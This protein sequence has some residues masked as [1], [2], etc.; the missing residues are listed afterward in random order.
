MSSCS[1]SPKVVVL[2]NQHVFFRRAHYGSTTIDLQGLTGLEF[3]GFLGQ[4]W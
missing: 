4:M 1:H 2:S 3:W